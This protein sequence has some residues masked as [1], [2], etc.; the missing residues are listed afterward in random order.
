MHQSKEQQTA[1][2]IGRI[3]CRICN[4]AT[5]L[6]PL[7]AVD[8]LTLSYKNFTTHRNLFMMP[9]IPL[10]TIKSSDTLQSLQNPTLDTSNAHISKKFTG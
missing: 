4:K 10:L 9:T 5:K 7:C 8:H 3:E 2:T 6:I 1:Q